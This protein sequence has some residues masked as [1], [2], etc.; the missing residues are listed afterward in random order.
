MPISIGLDKKYHLLLFLFKKYF[1][2]GLYLISYSELEKKAR[3][4]GQPYLVTSFLVTSLV[5]PV[6]KVLHGDGFFFKKK[7]GGEK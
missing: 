4:K 6:K 5:F 7:G 3:T 2:G 1:A